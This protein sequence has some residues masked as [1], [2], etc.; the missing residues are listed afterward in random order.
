M[1]TVTLRDEEVDLISQALTVVS[2][3]MFKTLPI[4]EML[5]DEVTASRAL[6]TASEATKPQQATQVPP[7]VVEA[8]YGVRKDG[9]PRGRPG[10]PKKKK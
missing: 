10:R 3:P 7:K 9:K 5:N 4:I 1:I 8:P 6:K 2:A